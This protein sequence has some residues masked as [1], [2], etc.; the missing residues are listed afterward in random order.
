MLILHLA[1]VIIREFDIIGIA[2]EEPETDA[3]LIIH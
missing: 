3:P 1:S 2:I